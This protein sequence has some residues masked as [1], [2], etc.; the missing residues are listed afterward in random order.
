MAPK[1]PVDLCKSAVLV[2][3]KTTKQ[4]YYSARFAAEHFCRQRLDWVDRVLLPPDQLRSSLNTSRQREALHWGWARITAVLGPT[5]TASLP[6]N[7]LEGYS[8]CIA[9]TR[10]R[11]KN[12][13][14]F[15]AV[16]AVSWAPRAAPERILTGHGPARTLSRGRF[17]FRPRAPGHASIAYEGRRQ[18]GTRSWPRRSGRRFMLEANAHRPEGYRWR[19]PCAPGT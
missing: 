18:R 14:S 19:L 6:S 4:A 10:N 12:G 5:L 13:R 16:A 9:T 1:S 17:L 3:P 15:E 7:S 2:S 8:I 11:K